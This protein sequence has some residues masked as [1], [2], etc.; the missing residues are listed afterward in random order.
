MAEANAQGG[1]QAGAGG[2]SSGQPAAGYHPQIAGLMDGV[3]RLIAEDEAAGAK[4]GAPGAGKGEGGSQK[5]PDGGGSSSGKPDQGGTVTVSDQVRELAKQLGF[6]DDEI[7]SFTEADVKAVERAGRR[8]SRAAARLGRE[9]QE[10]QEKLDK[11]GAA[12]EGRGGKPDGRRSQG[13]QGG[14]G[15]DGGSGE[16]V[17]DPETFGEQGAKL[18]NAM[19]GKIK[20]LEG[21]LKEAAADREEK[22]DRQWDED[23]G[24]FIK[25]LPQEYRSRFGTAD[26]GEDSDEWAEQEKLVLTAAAVQQAYQ[27]AFKEDLDLPKALGFALAIVA[28]D[29]M[30]QALT[31]EVT[32]KL[33]GELKAREGQR[34]A[35]PGGRAAASFKP[36]TSEDEQHAAVHEKGR[37]LGL[38]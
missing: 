4:A 3:K 9:K 32:A 1:S 10:L 29:E 27:Q 37:E 26:A 31:A 8:Y 6:K 22:D 18:L 7:K 34:S 16:P 33:T 23:V 17:F 15:G 25:S 14:Q 30:R 36:D 20:S 35:P 2:A 11:A 28:P 12:P 19:A 5:P 24:A 13:S 21:E 38:W